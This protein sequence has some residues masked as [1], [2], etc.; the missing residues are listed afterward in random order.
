MSA[1]SNGD[2]VRSYVTSSTLANVV[3]PPSILDATVQLFSGQIAS[4]SCV[5]Y[6]FKSSFFDDLSVVEMSSRVFDSVIEDR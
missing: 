1:E 2:T 6:S 3:S 4:C 5:K